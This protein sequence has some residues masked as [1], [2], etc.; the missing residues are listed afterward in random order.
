[1]F[2]KV[3]CYNQGKPVFCG[4]HVAPSKAK[5]DREI[6]RRSYNRQSDP[7][8]ELCYAG[9]T[10]NQ[11]MTDRQTQSDPYVVLCFAGN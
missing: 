2:F 10:K 8:V 4:M 1:M 3:P 7:Y 6:D 9:A 5:C 11:S